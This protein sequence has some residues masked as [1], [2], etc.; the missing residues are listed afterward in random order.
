MNPQRLLLIAS[1]CLTVLASNPARGA[2]ETPIS[3]AEVRRKVNERLH[4][5]TGE[6]MLPGQI[7]KLTLSDAFRYLPPADTEF[8]LTKLW[9]NPPGQHTL[10]MIFP[11][12][13]SPV[14]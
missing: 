5:Q 10:G 14:S 11:R 8:V 12:D 9:G 7:A 6:V 13:M 1:A 2:A 3:E 4:F